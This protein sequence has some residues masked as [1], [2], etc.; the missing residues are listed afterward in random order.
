MMTF[1]L[2][3]FSFASKPEV[4]RSRKPDLRQSRFGVV[5]WTRMSLPCFGGN[6]AGCISLLECRR[7]TSQ[8]SIWL[9][10]VVTWP[11]FGDLI[12]N[13]QSSSPA[14]QSSN[15]NKYNGNDDSSH[16]LGAF[17]YYTCVGFFICTL[18]RNLHG[19]SVREM[20]SPSL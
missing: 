20:A 8:K 13:S 18:S 19:H 17:M 1:D 10:S 5:P 11:E 9:V 2:S 15:N 6:S 16:L 14:S 7:S 3:S 12:R 4:G